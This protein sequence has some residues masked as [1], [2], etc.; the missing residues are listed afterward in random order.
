LIVDGKA[1]GK[2]DYVIRVY[3]HRYLKEGRGILKIDSSAYSLLFQKSEPATL[4]LQNV[5]QVAILL[6]D[7]DRIRRHGEVDFV[8]LGEIPGY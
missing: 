6:G 2:V 8:T 1:V 5:D 3:Q 4:E 7:L